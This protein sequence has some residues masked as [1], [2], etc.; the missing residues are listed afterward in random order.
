MLYK[1]A[2]KLA[3]LLAKVIFF[4]QTENTEI[5]PKEGGAVICANHRS[6]WDPV[7]L[8]AAIKRPMAYI[9]KE[10]LFRNKIFGW[11]LRQL[12]C[13]PVQRGGGDMAVVKTAVTLLKKGEV[14]VVFPEGE[15]IRKGKK[16]H[17]KPGAFRLAMMAGVPVI[18]AGIGG[19]FKVFRKMRLA[20][21]EKIDTL[22]YKKQRPHEEEYNQIIKDIMQTTYSLAGMEDIYA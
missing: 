15:R 13:Y 17:P 18:P 20:I 5:V 3:W 11:L 14:L 6:F 21:G 8:A 1:I 19:S 7:L 12:H 9:G 16:P 2:R 10:E 22:P 4:F